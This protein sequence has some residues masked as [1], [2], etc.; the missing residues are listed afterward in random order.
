MVERQYKG[1]YN[2][3]YS[4]YRARS[5]FQK[6]NNEGYAEQDMDGDDRNITNRTPS[7]SPS[8]SSS[9]L[10]DFKTAPIASKKK[11]YG[12][13][14]KYNNNHSNFHHKDNDSNSYKNSNGGNKSHYIYNRD[15]ELINDSSSKTKRY[16]RFNSSSGNNHKAENNSEEYGLISR[17]NDNNKL[18]KSYELR[19]KYFE[20]IQRD[21][22]KSITENKNKELNR[23]FEDSET[24]RDTEKDQATEKEMQ[25]Q[26]SGSKH[27][28]Q[29]KS[30]NNVEVKTEKE[31]AVEK[32]LFELRIL[33]ESLLNNEIDEFTIKVYL[34]S[35][36][37]AVSLGYYETYLP[38]ILFLISNVINN[39]DKQMLLMEYEIKE[40]ISIYI[41]HLLHFNN[42]IN[43]TDE[44]HNIQELNEIFS[45]DLNINLCY[46][47]YYRYEIN[48]NV[49]LSFINSISARSFYKWFETYKILETNLN[50]S[51]LNLL[52]KFGINMNI[53]YL[54]FH[55][56]S[57]Y[58]R[59]KISDFE[60]DFLLN[61]E[62]ID[63][64][65]IVDKYGSARSRLKLCNH[66]IID[67][68]N[69]Y[70]VIK[71]KSQ[72]RK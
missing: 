62:D 19:I 25:I 52:R 9:S 37:I 7:P 54:I 68:E 38:S 71:E 64:D 20:K 46:K 23:L 47:L 6:N 11:Y 60:K 1:Y 70:I 55:I 3:P 36:K 26:N 24:E 50:L 10:N 39:D 41:L 65:Y 69:N 35:I 13:S 42:R 67:R 51:Y 59:I 31:N 27:K 12:K 33:R 17:N 15:K 53:I 14:S 29:I 21:F 45:N 5:N 57:C 72:K 44:I 4:R 34:Y 48:D 22:L 40:I 63:L 30:T 28:N 56:N 32:T 16:L 61:V 8:F 43:K 18:Q 66:W 49:I 58:P 2:R